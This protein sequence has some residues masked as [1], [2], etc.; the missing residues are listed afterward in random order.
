MELFIGG[1]PYDW[2]EKDL[3]KQ[4][5]SYGVIS[6]KLIADRST[7]KSKGFGFITL[8]ND[9]AG[10]RAIAEMNGRTVGDGRKL[11]V[12]QSQK[13]EGTG[14]TGAMQPARNASADGKGNRPFPK[15]KNNS[16]RFPYRFASRPLP[17]R[18][19]P[20]LHDRLAENRFDVA[21]EVAWTALSPVA[22][23]PVNNPD[24][25][26]TNP[27]NDRGEYAGYS[28][29]WLTM[30][31]RPVVSPFTVK[32]AVANGFA[33]LLGG[34]Y[35][36]TDASEG[37]KSIEQGNYPYNGGWKRYRVSMDGKSLPGILM[38]IEKVPEGR[39]VEI[40]PC[41][42][43]FCDDGPKLPFPL[44]KY[45]EVYALVSRDRGHRPSIVTRLTKNKAELAQTGQKVLTLQYF[46]PY[47]HG[48]NLGQHGKHHHRLFEAKGDTVSGTIPEIDFTSDVRELE[49]RVYMGQFN[50]ETDKRW[51]DDLS[52][53][54]RGEWVYYELFDGQ[55]AH[56]GKNFLFKALFHHPDTIPSG[57]S[58]C[59][60]MEVLCPRC[61]MFGMTDATKRKNLPA[62]GFRGRFLS[63]ALVCETRLQERPSKTGVPVEQEGRVVETQVSV[64]QW[65]T[66]DGKIAGRQVLMPLQGP[67]KPSKRDVDGYYD[68]KSGLIKGSKSYHHARG[69]TADLEALGR[70]IAKIDSQREM[71]KGKSK[72]THRLRNYAHVLESGLVFR[73]T[74]GATN[75][76]PEE[77]AAFIILLDERVARHGF[78]VGLGKAQGLGSMA[79]RIEKV[80]LRRP[81][82]EAW[83]SFNTAVLDANGL[84]RIINENF[85]GLG[86]AVDA[87]LAVDDLERRL[88]TID[89]MNQSRCVYPKP[90]LKYWQ[91]ARKSGLGD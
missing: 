80:W 88:N 37:H 82:D 10:R 63:A 22:A 91:E 65:E 9:E 44:Q 87:L 58:L 81:G 19:K 34:C 33:N 85:H 76:T 8:A 61:S 14:R 57:A 29:R 53:L 54:N 30:D 70:T 52:R 41:Q 26:D 90:G 84:K 56:M 71:D 60:D 64:T 79:S 83:Q 59:T 43:Y 21:F 23:N 16:Q 24:A 75:C 66:E 11:R 51:F 69:E 47:A 77:A 73:G 68:L 46:G 18:R 28:L 17:E 50:H 32:S 39:K 74:L 48:M 45:E 27:V 89:D 5:A 38:G 1:L 67:P 20:P 6:A 72:Y 62:V 86:E 13:T 25:P 31:E 35:R 7:G 55:V 3:K 40:Q 15:S 49:K 36:V 12:N 42:E 2:Q 4:F 78:K